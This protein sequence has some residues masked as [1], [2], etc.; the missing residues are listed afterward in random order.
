MK[1]APTTTCSWCV[2]FIVLG[3]LTLNLRAPRHTLC[4]YLLMYV[5]TM[6][7]EDLYVYQDLPLSSKLSLISSHLWTNECQKAST[8]I[9]FG[10]LFALVDVS[11]FLYLILRYQEKENCG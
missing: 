2:C 6:I 4:S 5:S 8:N 11:S 3:S 1:D 10:I 7:T 9:Y